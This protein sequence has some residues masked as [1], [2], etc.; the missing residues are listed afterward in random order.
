MGK[1]YKLCLEKLFFLVLVRLE[2]E[3][4]LEPLLLY[5]PF[6]LHLLLLLLLLLLRFVKFFK[7]RL[8]LETWNFVHTLRGLRQAFFVKR[9]FWF[10]LNLW[11][12]KKDD[13]DYEKLKESKQRVSGEC[14]SFSAVHS[15]SAW[16]IW[17]KIEKEQAAQVWQGAI[18]LLLFTLFQ[19]VDYDNYYKL[20]GAKCV[21]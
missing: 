17:W 9:L 1:K 15:I 10:D 12:I 7:L 4:K 16:W 6:L 20:C 2:F 3:L 13:D 14:A 8:V 11:R 18:L 19:H 21:D 5:S